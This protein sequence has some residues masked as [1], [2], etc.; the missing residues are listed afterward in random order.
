MANLDMAVLWLSTPRAVQRDHLRGCTFRPSFRPGARSHH[1]RIAIV[2]SAVDVFP[3]AA[4]FP[5]PARTGTI[6]CMFTGCSTRETRDLRLPIRQRP[7]PA[8]RERSCVAPSSGRPRHT[9][10]EPGLQVGIGNIDLGFHGSCGFVHFVRESRDVPR[11]S[12][13]QRGNLHVHRLTQ[14]HETEPRIPAPATASRRS[15]FSESRTTGMAWVCE[16]VPA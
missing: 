6:A 12:P 5:V 7:Q 13:M 11:K 10:P 9:C 8:P 4:H 14:A 16:D 1:H 2:H 3:P 15:P